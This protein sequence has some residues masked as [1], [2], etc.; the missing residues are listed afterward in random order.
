M[1]HARL[2][3]ARAAPV[4]AA[5]ALLSLLVG[6]LAAPS[7]LLV[8]RDVLT[9]HLPL[10]ATAA[11]LTLEHGLPEWNAQIS[12][13]QPI[14][15][16]PNYAAFYPPSWLALAVPPGYA[17][18]L[19][20]IGH[21]ALALAGAWR[22][23]RRLGAEPQA[24]ALGAMGYA[25]AAWF[26]ALTHTFNFYCGMAWFPWALAAADRLLAAGPSR[27]GFGAATLGGALALQLLAGEPVA[28]LITALGV[29]CLFLSRP[30]SW[31]HAAPRLGLATVFALLF[32][33][34][35]LLPTAARL[36][37]S[38]RASGIAA[39]AAGKWSTHPARLVDLVWPHFWGDA[40]RDEEGLWL[41][42]EVHDEGFPYV[43][44]LYSGALLLVLAV[45]AT[46]FPIPYRHAW[47]LAAATGALLAL[48]RYNPLWE[49]LR[50]VV[51]LL[52]LVRYPEKFLVLTAAVVPLAGALGWQRLLEA[53]QAGNRRPAGWALAVATVPLVAVAA[54]LIL[55]QARPEAAA[56]W[57]RAHSGLPPSP[58]AVA[59]TLA[60]L[61]RE[62]VVAM[63]LS[64]GAVAVLALLRRRRVATALV[65][66]LAMLLLGVD[67]L[68]HGRGL[69]PTLPAATV[70]APPPLLAT[71]GA[72]GGRL[73]VGEAAHGE[74]EIRL[75]RGPP[76][77]QQLWGRRERLDPYV[78]TLW[79]AS[80]A[81]NRDYDLMLTPWGRYALDLVND[82]PVGPARDRLLG[83]WD[84]RTI[85]VPRAPSAVMRELRATRRL[86]S[87]VEIRSNPEALPRF[88]FVS[89]LARVPDRAAAA[90]ALAAAGYD[91]RDRDACVGEGG[92]PPG[93]YT[94]AQLTAVDDAG[95]TLHLRYRAMGPALLVAA[96][97]FDSGWEATSAAGGGA[98]P[99]CPTLAGQLAVAVPAGEH[100]LAL[101]YRDPWARVG[102]ALTGS[103]LL[104]LAVAVS[105][106][107]RP[108]PPAVQ[109]AP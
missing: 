63:A 75:R 2:S 72:S 20:V 44:A 87:E 85:V 86:P 92:P 48:G 65:P 32:G 109:S 22:L 105:R 106:R 51:P 46:R 77:F 69:L 18:S 35:Q 64:A 93:V 47:W 54:L 23:L 99:T 8:A 9:F 56:A 83:L 96:V 13:G 101:R 6:H 66:A 21:A 50:T 49:P 100:D 10:R 5:V 42:W 26:L 76:G 33:A 25:G 61:Q 70:L 67:L 71:V 58:E 91:L 98:L 84:V 24:A 37:G 3:A 81:A 55:L 14:L 62:A 31:R 60:F 79:G 57:V 94:P 103:T 4:A 89:A 107:R 16:N 52:G 43:I 78:A 53:R 82:A 41:G 17:L 68:W 34:V 90:T 80:Y 104:G 11:G 19:L 1:R 30:A 12:G 73:Y 38:V 39:D 29:S 97:T 88:R 108:A 59:K 95:Q 15:S 7:A 28:V 36:Q 74:P 40:L 102:A 45:A 27:R